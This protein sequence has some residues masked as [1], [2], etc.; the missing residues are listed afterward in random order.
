MY[1]FAMS[2]FRK[3]NEKATSSILQF[4]QSHPLHE[5]HS[6]GKRRKCDVPVIDGFRMPSE[7]TE[8]N[9]SKRAMLSLVLLKS[10]RTLESL[11]GVADANN[12]DAWISAFETWKMTRSSSVEALMEN[13]E[14]F[15]RGSKRAADQARTATMPPTDQRID[16]E[17]GDI[18][19]DDNDDLTGE[20]DANMY[21]E[22]CHDDGD[23]DMTSLWDDEENSNVVL[24]SSS[25]HPAACPTSASPAGNAATILE[26]FNTHGLLNSAASALARILLPNWPPEN[27]PPLDTMKQW[28]SSASADNHVISQSLPFLLREILRLWSF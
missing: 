12:E 28:V 7:D 11:I 1:E 25:L 6:L 24:D 14:D 26:I 3:K 21:S 22:E 13:M 10:F 23:F 27:I 20:G 4:L 16:T 5:T 9:R 17:V 15:Y 19:S 18:S 8:V 2:Y